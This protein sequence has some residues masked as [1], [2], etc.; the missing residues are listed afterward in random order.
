MGWSCSE[1]VIHKDLQIWITGTE[2]LEC[3]AVLAHQVLQQLV[4]PEMLTGKSH[5]LLA[6]SSI[7]YGS[8][9]DN[10]VTCPFQ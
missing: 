4:L 1:L 6:C 10:L 8:Q 2:T 5:S 7:Y 3:W 9:L